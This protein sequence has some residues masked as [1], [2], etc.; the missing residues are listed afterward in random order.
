[1]KPEA[2]IS[3]I[4]AVIL[5]IDGVLTDGRVGYGCGSDDEIKFFDVQ[6]G[7]GIRLLI[8][9]GVLVG[10]L[11]GRRSKANRRRAEELR[12]SFMVEGARDKRDGFARLL[13]QQGLEAC[14]CLYVGDDLID[15]PVM[16]QV[17]VAVAVGN[18]VDEVKAA[19]HWVCEKTGGRGA[20]REVAERLLKASGQ[21]Q[22]VVSGYRE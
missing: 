15:L 14:Q 2:D 22:S 6:D 3:Q 9:S 16:G 19:A 8:E 10:V 5:D 11:S 4:K 13:Q 21:W 7:L 1:M 12:L 18:A 20:V 17:G